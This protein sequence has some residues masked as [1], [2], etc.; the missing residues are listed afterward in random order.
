MHLS[1]KIVGSASC[2]L[3]RINP[4]RKDGSSP[5]RTRARYGKRYGLKMIRSI[6]QF[7]LIA[8]SRGNSFLSLLIPIFFSTVD[9]KKLFAIKLF[10]P[11]R[12]R[13]RIGRAKM[14]EGSAKLVRERGRASLA[15]TQTS[16]QA[17]TREPPPPPPSL[18]KLTPSRAS[19]HNL[20]LRTYSDSPRPVIIWRERLLITPITGG[21][22]L[23]FFGYI[24]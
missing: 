23:F 2:S 11:N 7:I 21:I 15:R 4:A 16:I 19:C 6:P 18:P 12:R 20:H 8:N 17:L 9:G 5:S 24:E 14:H 10:V 13:I 1:C 3:R 22:I